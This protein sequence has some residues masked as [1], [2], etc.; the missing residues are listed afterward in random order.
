MEFLKEACVESLNQAV[1]A[2]GLNADRIEICRR[3]DLDGITPNHDI[4]IRA[5]NTLKV[6]VKIMIRPRE[7]NFIY[8]QEEFKKMISQIKFCK[9]IGV[10]EVVFGALTN[11]GEI[12]VN[13]VARMAEF[14]HP[15]RVTFHKAIDYSKDILNGIEALCKISNITSILTS[16]GKK[17]VL[18][19]KSLLRKIISEFSAEINIIVAGKI[20]NLNLKKVH[21]QIGATEYHGKRI[22]GKLI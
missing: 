12:D 10:S 8:N 17:S 4:I 11:T 5:I 2:Q 21:E 14:S 1:R 3:L 20:T 15:M 7:G 19:A 6:P 18:D 16:G 9:S 13:L 22:V